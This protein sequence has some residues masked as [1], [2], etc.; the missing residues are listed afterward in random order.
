[1]ALRRAAV[2]APAPG[3]GH[4]QRLGCTSARC[5]RARPRRSGRSGPSLPAAAPGGGG[6]GGGSVVVPPRRIRRAG[7]R[8]GAALGGLLDRAAR[9]LVL[10]GARPCRKM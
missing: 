5:I 6:V 2:T 7:G 4:V 1:M 10:P 3:I 8:L 9:S